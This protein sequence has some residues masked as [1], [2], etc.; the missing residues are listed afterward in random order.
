MVIVFC[1][2]GIVVMQVRGSSPSR[3]ICYRDGKKIFEVEINE[4]RFVNNGWEMK[5]PKTGKIVWIQDPCHE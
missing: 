3:F 1:L 4:A 2:V 5:D